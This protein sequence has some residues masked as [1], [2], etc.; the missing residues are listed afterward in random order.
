M[1]RSRLPRDLG[2]LPRPVLPPPGL[3][4]G[5]T[6]FGVAV[7]TSPISSPSVGEKEIA[8]GIVKLVEVANFQ[9][10]GTAPRTGDPKAAPVGG[11]VYI[12]PSL[13]LR[14]LHF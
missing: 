4:R 12:R 1:V 10:C 8:V 2:T 7:I 3:P 6:L 9:C 14:L 13:L 5:N 11:L